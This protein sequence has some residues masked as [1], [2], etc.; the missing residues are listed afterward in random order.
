RQGRTIWSLCGLS[1]LQAGRC[2]TFSTPGTACR[3]L[4]LGSQSTVSPSS[5]TAARTPSHRCPAPAA[6]EL[7]CAQKAFQVRCSCVLPR[8]ASTPPSH[9]LHLPWPSSTSCCACQ[10]PHNATAAAT[11]RKA[12]RAYREEGPTCSESSPLPCS[13][14]FAAPASCLSTPPGTD[15]A[16]STADPA[17][18]PSIVSL[19]PIL[20]P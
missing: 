13:L 1:R 3:G 9:L 11:R 5:S 18:P 8:L 17:P 20:L 16:F 6:V 2:C 15:L 10:T 19:R 12:H 4:Y 7:S 14:T